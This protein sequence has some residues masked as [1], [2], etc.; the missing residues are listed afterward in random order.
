M[1]RAV[2]GY[3]LT[4]LQRTELHISPRYYVHVDEH[5]QQADYRIYVRRV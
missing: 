5:R 2:I 3:P 1:T 4:C